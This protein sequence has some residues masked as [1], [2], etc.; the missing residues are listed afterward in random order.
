MNAAMIILAALCLFSSLL[1]IPGIKESVLDPVVAAIMN[2]AGY[3]AV[4]LGAQK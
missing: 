1:V 3:A 4:V 2:K